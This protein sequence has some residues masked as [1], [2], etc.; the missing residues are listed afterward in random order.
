VGLAELGAPTP[1]QDDAHDVLAAAS[2]MSARIDA[3]LAEQTLDARPVQ[4]PPGGVGVV[5]MLE[6]VAHNH[7]RRAR[8]K[9]VELHTHADDAGVVAATDP[10]LLEDALDNLVSNAVKFATGGT[11]VTLTSGRAPDG[12]VRIAVRDEGP[13][14]TEADRAWLFQKFARLS[15]R[16]TA[17]EPSTGLGLFSV[18]QIVDK[19]GGAIDLTTAPGQGATFQISLPALRRSS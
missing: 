13:G 16:P 1:L 6:A 11:R 10:T 18:K 2:A 8:S 9:G 5:P 14:F 15:A 7:R 19:L 17:G 4:I 12:H 3:L